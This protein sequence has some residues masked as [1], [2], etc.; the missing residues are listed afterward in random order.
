VF[1]RE[2]RTYNLKHLK[3][4]IEYG[5]PGTDRFAE[6]LPHPW[7]DFCEQYYFND[8]VFYDHLSRQHYTC[9]LCKDRYKNVYYEAYKNLETHFAWSHYLCPYEICKAKCFQAFRTE[10][11]LSAH[12]DLMHRQTDSQKIRADG[13]LG[14]DYD[15]EEGNKFKKN[16]K[17]IQ[18]DEGIKDSEGIDFNFYFS[19]KYNFIN[20][21]RKKDLANRY[22]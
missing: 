17:V 7:C 8:Q 5:D 4:H 10:Q 9:P 21:K 3:G 6:I 18:E 13:L 12:L 1:I 15:N 16:K 22:Q 14:F 11:E 2:Q 20:D 19:E